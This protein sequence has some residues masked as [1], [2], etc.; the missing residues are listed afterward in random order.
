MEENIKQTTF[1]AISFQDIR[2]GEIYDTVINGRE[3]G[4]TLYSGVYER[5][6]LRPVV[7]LRENG[8][9]AFYK[10]DEYVIREKKLFLKNAQEFLLSDFRKE[11][12]HRVLEQRGL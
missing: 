8:S 9:V 5:R 4:K 3:V 2:V 1:W 12:G 6:V 7:L 10:F 11:M